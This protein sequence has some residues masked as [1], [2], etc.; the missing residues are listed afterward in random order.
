MFTLTLTGLNLNS[1]FGTSSSV[2]AG[3]LDQII[4]QLKRQWFSDYSSGHTHGRVKKGGTETFS[5]SGSLK[6]NWIR[7]NMKKSL[8]VIKISF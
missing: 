6:A 7:P 1:H 2:P 3:R 5:F 8:Q 4:G